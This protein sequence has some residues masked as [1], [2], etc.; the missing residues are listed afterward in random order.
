MC[1][2]VGWDQ[3]IRIKKIGRFSGNSFNRERFFGDLYSGDL[4][5]WGLLFEVTVFGGLF[6]EDLFSADLF[7]WIFFPGD[8]CS[9]GP[10]FR[11]L[12]SA[13]RCFI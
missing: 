4:F 10:F 13:Y 1:R 11:A 5:S 9:S 2:V 3:S 8:F 6:S 12:L 7:A